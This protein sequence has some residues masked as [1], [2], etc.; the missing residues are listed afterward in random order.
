MASRASLSSDQIP[1][2]V[3]QRQQDNE[4]HSEQADILHRRQKEGDV[5]LPTRLLAFSDRHDIRH[6]Q[7]VSPRDTSPLSMQFI[8]QR[9]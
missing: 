1:E 3:Q 6:D 7:D 5:N 4:G 9:M 8:F 2:L